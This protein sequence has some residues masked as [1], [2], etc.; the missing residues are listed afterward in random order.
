M[1]REVIIMCWPE[2][3]VSQETGVR[4]RWRSGRIETDIITVLHAVDPIGS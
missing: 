1:D 2:C 4:D 3:G